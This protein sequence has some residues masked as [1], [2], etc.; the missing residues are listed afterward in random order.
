MTVRLPEL[1]RKIYNSIVMVTKLLMTRSPYIWYIYYPPGLFSLWLDRCYTNFSARSF[2]STLSMATII[3]STVASLPKPF[4]DDKI[5]FF[6]D[7]API[8][9][10]LLYICCLLLRHLLLI[11][12]W[13]FSTHHLRHR[14]RSITAR[15]QRFATGA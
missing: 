6:Q 12:A 14:R 1:C 4:F 8:V 5:A 15:Q 13:F 9:C 2:R 7:I 10:L 3:F 11:S